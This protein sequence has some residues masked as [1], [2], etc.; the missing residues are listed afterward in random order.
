MSI[1]IDDE[2]LI[3]G[4]EAPQPAHPTVNA[5]VADKPSFCGVLADMPD[6]PEIY[7]FTIGGVILVGGKK[8]GLTARH[9]LEPILYTK[10]PVTQPRPQA[11]RAALP[12]ATKIGKVVDLDAEAGMQS[13][14]VG[15]EEHNEWGDDYMNWILVELDDDLPIA[16]QNIHNAGGKPVV[17]NKFASADEMDGGGEIDV[18]FQGGKSGLVQGSLRKSAFRFNQGSIS[19]MPAYSVDV[20]RQLGK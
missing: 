2:V 5:C 12:N 7:P 1:V 13:F 18:W 6:A 8:Y 4:G 14:V 9:K 3:V 17:I 20:E 10:N 19:L 16:Q 11:E 15:L